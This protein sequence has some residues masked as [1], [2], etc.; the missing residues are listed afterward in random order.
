VTRLAAALPAVHFFDQLL[1]EM[2]SDLG[3]QAK[4]SNYRLC[5][6]YCCQ[7]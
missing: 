4:T 1:L 5:V 3:F 7:P 6:L 2:A